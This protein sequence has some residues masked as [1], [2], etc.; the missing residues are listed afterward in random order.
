M[1]DSQVFSLEKKYFNGTLAL[2]VNKISSN[3]LDSIK[4][5]Y[6]ICFG[7]LYI[8]STRPTWLHVGRTYAKVMFLGLAPKCIIK[9]NNFKVLFIISMN[10][11]SSNHL[12]SIKLYLHHGSY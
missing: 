9:S 1:V 6:H 3:N 10:Y 12:Q 7:P 2:V 4:Y 8:S 5:T 11:V